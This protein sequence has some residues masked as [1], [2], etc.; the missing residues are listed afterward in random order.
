[1]KLFNERLPFENYKKKIDKSTPEK[2]IAI[3]TP[4]RNEPEFQEQKTAC[5]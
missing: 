4:A 5:E 3:L 2:V 1:M